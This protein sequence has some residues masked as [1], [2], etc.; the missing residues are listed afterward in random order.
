MIRTAHQNIAR[1]IKSVMIRWV[2]HVACKDDK[3]IQGFSV[4]TL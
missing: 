1:A 4:E 2:R 3:R